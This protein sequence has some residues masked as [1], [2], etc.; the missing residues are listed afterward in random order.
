MVVNNALTVRQF[1]DRLKQEKKLTR[2]I[3]TQFGI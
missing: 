2:N 3:F 1:Q